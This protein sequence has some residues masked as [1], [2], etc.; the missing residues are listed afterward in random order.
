MDQNIAKLQYLAY[1]F[2]IAGTIIDI[3]PTEH[4]ST[5]VWHPV[6]NSSFTHGIFVYLLFTSMFIYLLLIQL[7]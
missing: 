1:E 4:S 2:K 3:A 7:Y 5:H 6:H